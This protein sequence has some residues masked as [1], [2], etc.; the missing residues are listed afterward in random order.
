MGHRPAGN[1][2]VVSQTGTMNFT[3]I[4][5]ARPQFIKLAVICRA[6]QDLP[7]VA[8]HQIIHTGQHYDA[9]MS[10]VFFQDLAI[11]AP[12]FHLGVGSGS[13]GEQTGEM[14]KRLEPVLVEH[15]PDWVLLY[16]D[17]N[18]TLAGAVVCSKLG[19]PVAHIEAGL[20]SFNRAMPEEINR[21]VAD[22]LSDVLFCPTITAVR[23]LEKEGLAARA[24]LCGD[25]M[26]DA[27]IH[28]RKSAAER[29][30][31]LAKEWQ[32]GA[33]ILATVHR[34]E[35]TDDPRR[36]RSIFGALE[37]IAQEVCP[38]LMP[39]H[40]RTKKLLA[41]AGIELRYVTVIR[42][43]SY[44]EMLLLEGRARFILTDSGGVQKEAYFARVPCV[45]LRE[46]TEWVETL[47]NRCNVLTGADENAIVEAV[48]SDVP[49]GPWT[50]AYGSGS[51]GRAILLDLVARRGAMVFRS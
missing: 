49:R 12:D 42:P 16:G 27:A 1:E 37:Q 39:L 29:G 31:L 6:V 25:V 15:R 7:S 32:S 35:N 14:I 24:V 43:V 51:A 11:P 30:G 17:T 3:S 26:Y 40:P 23:N 9:E 33:F 22:H 47:E 2:S 19:I 50:E 34:A 44:L 5:G 46:E 8:V 28:Y 18:S 45:T 13:H 4:V 20:R 21:I 10:D 41:A 36:L 48:Q 38:I